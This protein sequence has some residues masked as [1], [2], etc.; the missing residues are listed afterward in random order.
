MLRSV[1]GLLVSV[2][3][4]AGCGGNDLSQPPKD[5]GDFR[6]GYNIVVAKNAKPVG[7]SRQASAEEWEAVLKKAVGD[8]MGR[9]QGDKLYHIGIGVDAYA[10][11]IPGIPVV[12][13][14][15]SVLAITVNVWDDTA[16]RTVN[17]EPKQFNVFERL[18][19]ETV[20]GSGLT[21][22][23]EQQM[24]NLATNAARIINDWLV[25]NKAWFTPEAVA[26]RAA[27][28]A[29]GGAGAGARVAPQ[30]APAAA[31]ATAP[32]TAP[33]APAN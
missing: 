22:S 8:R 31:P 9:Y 29:A 18:S 32:A 17:A 13:S 10:L 20:V 16:Q 7:P 3:L 1:F 2:A 15:K 11:A 25:E 26:A 30:T 27:L 33:V 21:Q 28:A 14:P 6:L 24:E 12:L 23:R 19:G 5:F 4:L